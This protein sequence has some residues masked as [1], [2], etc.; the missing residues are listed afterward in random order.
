MI[1]ESE[2]T[3]TTGK[4]KEIRDLMRETEGEMFRSVKRKEII[5]ET[6]KIEK[7]KRKKDE[8]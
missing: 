6:K 4:V 1:V 2:A 8:G 3:D 7:K 5:K